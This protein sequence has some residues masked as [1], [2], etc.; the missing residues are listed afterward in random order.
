MCIR[1]SDIPR[2]VRGPEGR[3]LHHD[4]HRAGRPDG[5][6]V[7]ARAAEQ[8]RPPSAGGGLF[9]F[10]SDLGGGRFQ[11]DLLAGNQKATRRQA[12]RF[13]RTPLKG[14][15]HHGCE[16]L[17]KRRLQTSLSQS[18]RSMNAA[19]SCSSS[20]VRMSM[21]RHSRRNSSNVSR[22]ICAPRS[23]SA[24]SFR[25]PMTSTDLAFRVRAASLSPSLFQWSPL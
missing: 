9:V 8:S 25:E 23:S 12:R 14:R 5:R 16:S 22:M 15:M 10:R 21:V 19:L 6:R 20:N 24:N 18:L 7:T 3:G 4:P 13:A 11:G 1:D 17:E 2:R